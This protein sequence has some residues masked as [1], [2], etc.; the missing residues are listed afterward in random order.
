MLTL[1]VG[2]SVDIAIGEKHSLQN[3]SDDDVEIIEL[4]QG[5]ILLEEDIIRYSDMYGRC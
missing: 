1:K 2:Q 5:S 4:Q 3:L